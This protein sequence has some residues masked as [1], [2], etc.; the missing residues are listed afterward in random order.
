MTGTSQGWVGSHFHRKED[1]RLITGRGRFL[2]DLAKPGA[3]HIVFR[4]SDHAHAM[5][6]SI[7]VSAAKTMPGVV[8]VVTGDDIKDEILPM[9]QPVVQPALPAT[10]PKH[11]PLAVGRGEWD[12]EPGG[13]GGRGSRWRR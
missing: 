13:G 7:D 5:I 10:Y 1:H 3:L 4:R 6:E 12:G 11:W 2:A 9:P 8:A